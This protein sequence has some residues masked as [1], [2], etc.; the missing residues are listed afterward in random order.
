MPTPC[1]QFVAQMN[2]RA[3]CAGVASFFTMCFFNS[4]DPEF[5]YTD[6][7]RNSYTDHIDLFNFMCGLDLDDPAY[8]AGLEIRTFLPH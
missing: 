5:D 2:L 6:E 7:Q 3:N 8:D 4:E 1:V